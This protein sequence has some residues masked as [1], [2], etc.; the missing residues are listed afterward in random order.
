MPVL[1]CCA[2]NPF[3]ER[4]AAGR[5]RLGAGFANP[6]S[7]SQQAPVYTHLGPHP[8][9]PPLPKM[10]EGEGQIKLSGSP[11]PALW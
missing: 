8:L 11:S 6:I 3:L 10:G 1:T 4:E 7:L 2:E 9:S 5:D